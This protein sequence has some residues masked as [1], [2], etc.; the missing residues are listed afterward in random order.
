MADARAREMT[1]ILAEREEEAA[2]LRRR[3][4]AKDENRQERHLLLGLRTPA[5]PS[6]V[7][8]AV[9][10]PP[11]PPPLPLA[12]R[13]D[14]GGLSA[15]KAATLAAAAAAGV[16]GDHFDVQVSTCVP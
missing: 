10:P 3:L 12:P 4:A 16:P 11:L 2:A 5:L 13:E 6:G 15:G 14:A 1:A 9:P 8:S 7:E